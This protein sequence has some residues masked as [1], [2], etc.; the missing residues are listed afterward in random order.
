MEEKQV[1][2]IRKI[3]AEGVYKYDTGQF[4]LSGVEGEI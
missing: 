1:K 4:L 2:F 3:Y